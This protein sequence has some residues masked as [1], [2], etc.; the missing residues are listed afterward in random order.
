MHRIMHNPSA[1]SHKGEL[2]AL[3]M[4]GQESLPENGMRAKIAAR[5]EFLSYRVAA[6]LDDDA[7]TQQSNRSAHVSALV[8][9][10]NIVGIRIWPHTGRQTAEIVQLSV[11][12]VLQACN[13]RDNGVGSVAAG[14]HG[15]N[16][17]LLRVISH[18]I[19]AGDDN[20]VHRLPID[21]SIECQLITTLN[22]IR[23]ETNPTGA[24]IR[25]RLRI[26][27][28]ALCTVER[29]SSVIRD[30]QHFVTKVA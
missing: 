25:D 28:R 11:V 23:I 18:V 14:L 6:G 19:R 22:R 15:R 16:L 26:W 4:E 17:Y 2:Y 9:V 24:R 10:R 12:R 20:L 13:Q 1:L 3:D 8:G 21:Q 27:H 29:E 5:V 7:A 30:G